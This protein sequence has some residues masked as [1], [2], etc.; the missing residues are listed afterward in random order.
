MQMAFMIKE[1]DRITAKDWEE[2]CYDLSQG[3]RIT[4]V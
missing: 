1:Y 4:S 2:G 3:T